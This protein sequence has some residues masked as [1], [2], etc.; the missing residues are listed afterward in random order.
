MTKKS[1]LFRPYIKWSLFMNCSVVGMTMSSAP[2]DMTAQAAPPQMS[3]S[4]KSIGVS[5]VTSV[6]PAEVPAN[7]APPSYFLQGVNSLTHELAASRCV[8][9]DAMPSWPAVNTSTTTGTGLRFEG[10]VDR[11]TLENRI[12]TEAGM[13]IGWGKLGASLGHSVRRTFTRSALARYI[14]MSSEVRYDR[15]APYTGVVRLSALG[16]SYKSP[17]EFLQNCGN[18]FVVGYD[19][20]GT[21]DAYFYTQ[22]ATLEDYAGTEAAANLAVTYGSAGISAN[23]SKQIS[24]LQTRQ[25][26]FTLVDAKV[27]GPPA[28]P[29]NLS[30]AELMRFGLTFNKTVAG[31]P[32]ILGYVT[33]SYGS[34]V[35]Q[36]VADMWIAH[37]VALDKLSAAYIALEDRRKSLQLIHDNGIAN[38]GHVFSPAAQKELDSLNHPP[39]D[40]RALIEN[41]VMNVNCDEVGTA[42]PDPGG[43]IPAAPIVIALNPISHQQYNVSYAAGRVAL[44]LGTWHATRAGK[45]FY[46]DTLTCQ[47]NKMWARSHIDSTLTSEIANKRCN[48]PSDADLIFDFDVNGLTLIKADSPMRLLVYEHWMPSEVS[49]TWSKAPPVPITRP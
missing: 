49:C 43:P 13:K 30:S 1:W 35:D 47:N 33:V 15:I 32:G 40:Y 3:I 2:F 7:G 24:S 11:D 48:T 36:A 28:Q 22:S 26:S 38:L 14:H 20:G 45:I 41:C 27:V 37:V 31:S 18:A 17:R 34:L 23:F 19:P 8:E 12:K 46:C 42:I 39:V 44:V 21:F 6:S 10:G 9:V 5:V 25:R 4:S 29:S 16:A